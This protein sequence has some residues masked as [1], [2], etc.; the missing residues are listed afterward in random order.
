[1]FNE[2]YWTQSGEGLIR[3]DLCLEALRLGHLVATSAVATPRA[4][5]LVALMALQAARLPAR[6]D[7]LGE[8]VLL[9]DQDRARWD[10]RLIG[11]GFDHFDRSMIGDD[12]SEYHIQA[13]IAAT[14]TRAADP[15]SADWP[16]ILT[17]YDQLLLKNPSPV[18]ALNRAVATA[19][20]HGPA[21]AVR[22]LAPLERDRHLRNYHLLLAVRGQ[23]LLELGEASQAAD[24]FRAALACECSEPERRFL[25]R[26]LQLCAQ[27]GSAGF[28]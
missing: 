15:A 28:R 23:L 7:D 19:K 20:V 18:V 16:T 24:A 27:S 4:H 12:V 11:L 17:L 9:D 1:M 13:A 21:A 2:G 10:E 8:L 6:V 3:Q 5:A 25:E 22:A 26:K 14:H